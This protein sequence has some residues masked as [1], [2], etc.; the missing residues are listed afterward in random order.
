MLRCSVNPDDRD[1]AANIFTG[2]SSTSRDLR[3]IE[4]R[5]R[6]NPGR[7]DIACY[8]PDSIFVELETKDIYDSPAQEKD[9]RFIGTYAVAR[10]ITIRKKYESELELQKAHFQQ[11]FENSPDAI[12]ILDD[13]DKVVNINKG[14]E[15]LFAYS[16]EECRNQHINDLI[17][18]ADF[19]KEATALSKVVLSSGL[20]QHTESRRK[21]KDGRII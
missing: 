4:L 16:P 12:A 18:P 20:A 2:R 1:R 3:C 10:N 9:K 7:K 6:C 21:R 13:T 11:L 8:G 5:F 14:F 19:Q 17:V 15:K